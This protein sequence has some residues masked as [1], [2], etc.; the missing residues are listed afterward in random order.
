MTR[1][2]GR[3]TGAGGVRVWEAFETDSAGVDDYP[4]FIWLQ[5]A[6]LLNLNES[7]FYADWG[8]PVQ[9]T[10]ATSIYPDYYTAK[11]QKRFSSYFPSCSISRIPS[12]DV[13]YSVNIT[14]KSGVKVSQSL[15]Q[16]ET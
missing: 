3:E 15:S 4:N 10:L 16:A 8:I 11:T 5:Q 6:L 12:S 14:T 7:P 9:Q 13:S 1:V 2:W